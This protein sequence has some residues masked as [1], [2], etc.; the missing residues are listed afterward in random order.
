MKNT[1][2]FLLTLLSIS[3]VGQSQNEEELLSRL[4]S[5][6]SDSDKVKIYIDLHNLFFKA[7][8]DKSE[9]YTWQM[10]KYGKA[11]HNLLWENKAYLGLARCYRKRR[12]Y[13][14]VLKYD[15]VSLLCTQRSGNAN[16]IFAAKLML[17]LLKLSKHGDGIM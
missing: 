14:Y 8:V 11:T 2:I 16:E 10:L 15:S 12:Q 17:K 7:N 3:A 9:A 6:Q 5:A 13:N 1:F 4:K